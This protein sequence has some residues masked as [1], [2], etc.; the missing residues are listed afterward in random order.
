[1][2]VGPAGCLPYGSLRL[3]NSGADDFSLIL[4]TAVL[5]KVAYDTA[6][7]WP[8]FADGVSLELSEHQ[9]TASGNDAPAAWC[10]AKS[11]FGND[12]ATPGATNGCP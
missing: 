2:A 5:D 4:G 12:K 6:A 11:A 3:N 8:T 10:K 9:L 7:G 1:V